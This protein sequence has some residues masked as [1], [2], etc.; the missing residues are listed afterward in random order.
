[1]NKYNRKNSM[2][3]L[4]IIR[5]TTIDRAVIRTFIADVMYSSRNKEAQE[6][7]IDNT[8]DKTIFVELALTLAFN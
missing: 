5:I 6:L 3:T 1:M 7:I 4:S 2:P 8:G